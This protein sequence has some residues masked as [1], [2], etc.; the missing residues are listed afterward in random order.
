MS[1]AHTEPLPW[2]GDPVEPTPPGV[3]H[4]VQDPVPGCIIRCRSRFRGRSS[5]IDDADH[6]LAEAIAAGQR[7]PPSLAGV[8]PRSRRSTSATFFPVRGAVHRARHERSARSC[9]VIAE[10]RGK[11]CLGQR[12]DHGVAGGLSGRQRRRLRAER[13][14]GGA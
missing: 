12:D 11:W 1:N 4:P 8:T 14:R 7:L 5:F 6:R 2:S 3:D 9:P 13:K 10:C